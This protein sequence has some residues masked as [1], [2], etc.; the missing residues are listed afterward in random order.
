[1]GKADRQTSKLEHQHTKSH[2]SI[3]IR[4]GVTF[5]FKLWL[6]S[7]KDV[8]LSFVALAAIILDFAKA[9]EGEPHRFY[10]V[11]RFG[12][13]IDKRIDLY[14]TP[15]TEAERTLEETSHKTDWR[16]L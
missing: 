8:V 1:M 10:S 9:R 3:L 11:M 13:Q 5:M 4:D 7:I 14:G 16:E 6:D 12:Q 2:R 15:K